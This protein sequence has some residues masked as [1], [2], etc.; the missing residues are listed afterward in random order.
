MAYTFSLNNKP[1]T[2]G[3]AVWL[4]K[5]ALVT[6]GWTVESSGDGAGGNFNGSGD[7]HAPGGPYAGSL[8][9]NNAWFRIRAPGGLPVREFVIQRV[10]NTADWRLW[11]SSDGTGFTGGAPSATTRPTAADEEGIFNT[12][13]GS[14][15]FFDTTDGR[16]RVDLIIGDAAEGYSFFFGARQSARQEGYTTMLYLDVVDEAHPSDSDPAVIGYQMD[17]TSNPFPTVGYQGFTQSSDS[18]TASRIKGWFDK[19]GQN[20]AFVTY[21]M[22]F[23]GGEEGSNRGEPLA[24]GRKSSDD[25]GNFSEESTWYW[26]GPPEHTT[27]T[28]RKGRSHLFR[29]GST[30]LG[31]LRPNAGGS[32]FSRMNLGMVTVP[33]D[34]STIPIY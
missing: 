10:T 5:E 19:G 11:Y 21:P 16:I 30:G 18:Q 6:A 25:T 17:A 24:D 26:R 7:V 3:E 34:G 23:L 29:A 20:P 13:S 27:E 14:T 2:N 15:N 9:E 12:P 8:D 4:W 22:I 31:F 1:T 33:W 32:P 28:G